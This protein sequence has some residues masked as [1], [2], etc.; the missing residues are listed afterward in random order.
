MSLLQVTSRRPLATLCGA[1]VR[2]FSATCARKEDPTKDLLNSILPSNDRGGL[3]FNRDQA[4]YRPSQQ[5]SRDS[6]AGRPASNNPHSYARTLLEDKIQRE[7]SLADRMDVAGLRAELE[8]QAP[9]RWQY[10]DVYAPHDLTGVE[11]KKWRNSRRTPRLDAFDT[12]GLNPLKEYKNF[13]IMSEYMTEM[14]R[15]KHSKVTGLRPRNHR[16]LAKAI[17]RA[18]GIGIMPSVHVHPELI[19]PSHG[20]P[21]G[22]SF[23]SA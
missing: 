19:K 22:G 20:A 10:G 3:G 15:I 7:S 1:S 6:I 13:S 12:L 9:R 11:A 2:A 8:T 14:G 5:Q 4:S 17:R 16:K 23:W 18:I 21:L